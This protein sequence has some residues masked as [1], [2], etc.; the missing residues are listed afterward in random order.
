MIRQFKYQRDK[1]YGMH[2]TGFELHERVPRYFEDLLHPLIVPKMGRCPKS[3]EIQT[4][5]L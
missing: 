4:I 1:R 3:A 2:H 5:S